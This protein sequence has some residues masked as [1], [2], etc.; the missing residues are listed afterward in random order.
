MIL[1]QVARKT[2]SNQKQFNL[3]LN[4]F[5]SA[6][7]LVWLRLNCME[8]ST[9]WPTSLKEH[10]YLRMTIGKLTKIKKLVLFLAT[11]IF[12]LMS[13]YSTHN[14]TAF[15]AISNPSVRFGEN[16]SAFLIPQ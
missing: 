11:L 10:Q 14:D 7:T 6:F 5:M 1:M 3:S 13:Y 9:I 8:I 15:G 16:D 4:F 12:C 2:Y